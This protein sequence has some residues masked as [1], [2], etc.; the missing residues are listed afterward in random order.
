LT[1]SG[2][3]SSKRGS[4]CFIRNATEIGFGLIRIRELVA[5]LVGFLAG[6]MASSVTPFS[7]LN[8]ICNKFL[9]KSHLKVMARVVGCR[10]SAYKLQ[11][12]VLFV[13]C[14]WWFL[15]IVSV[16]HIWPSISLLMD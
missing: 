11:F 16:L 12:K 13:P 6:S 1:L 2:L 10:R 4:G 7:S 14:V 9:N 3:H 5:Q 15:A 8:S